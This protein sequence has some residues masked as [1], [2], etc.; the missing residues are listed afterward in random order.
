ME[1]K[2][3]SSKANENL[4]LSLA[5]ALVA[6]VVG[7]FSGVLIFKLENPLLAIAGAIA[8]VF[9]L[10]SFTNLEFGLLALVFMVYTRTSDVLMKFHHFPSI[11]KPYIA[12]LVVAILV[13]WIINRQISGGWSRAAILVGAYG[14]VVFSSL[15]YAADF[16]YA[17]TAALNFLKDGIIAIIIAIL[18][19]N[20]KILEGVIWSLLLAGTFV[21]TISAY[22][23]FSGDSSNTFGGFGQIGYQNIVGETDGSRLSGPVGD[24]NFYAQ[25]M[26][27]LIPIALSRF[28]KE[29]RW[30]LKAFAGWAFLVITLAVVFSY[31]RGAVVAIGVMILFGMFYSPPRITDVFIGILLIAIIINFIPNPYM[32]RLA[33]IPDIFGGKKGV[34][35]DVSYRGRASEVIAAWLMFIDHPIV[36]VGVENYPVFYQSYSRKLG[37]DPRIEERQAHSL[38][39]QVAAETGL[40]GILVFGWL[41]ISMMKGMLDAVKKLKEAG[42]NWYADLILSFASGVVGYLAAALFIHGAYPRYFWLLAG[43]SLAIPHITKDILKNPTPKQDL[44]GI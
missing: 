19:R 22:Q 12:L 17:L 7:V 30:Y 6:A 42:N 18:L 37:L 28:L 8:L 9:A 14:L 11:A 39:L 27:I 3:Y 26:V 41:L 33:T 36:G 10:I 5:F 25:A 20:G 13:K 16:S 44:Y 24:P 1:Q 38:Y 15:L 4:W 34:L 21:G 43:I 31:S 32:E 23:G 35:G 29:N 2:S 40:A